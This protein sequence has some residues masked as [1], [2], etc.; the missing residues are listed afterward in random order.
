MMTILAELSDDSLLDEEVDDV[1]G[2]PG[3]AQAR[4]VRSHRRR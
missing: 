3:C 2:V 1:A 4:D